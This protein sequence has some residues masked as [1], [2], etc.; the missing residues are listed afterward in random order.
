[1]ATLIE[2]PSFDFTS[3][4]YPELL[5]ELI[6]F[7]R[8]N[9]P[10]I[11]DEN[12]NEPYVQILRAFALVGH[13]NNVNLDIAANETLFQTTRLLKSLQSHLKLIDVQLNQNIPASADV[14]LEFSKIFLV[15]TN[16]VPLNS[17]FATEETEEL[18]QINFSSII[19]YTIDPTNVPTAVFQ[20]DATVFGANK[21]VEASTDSVFFDMFDTTPAALDDKLYI[22]HKDILWDT[23]EFIF[24]TFG[25]DFTGV[26]EFYNGSTD[27]ENPDIVTDMGGFLTVNLTTL[28]GTDDRTNT[29]V[30]IT[31][32]PSGV[33]ET[34]NSYYSGGINYIDTVGILGQTSVSTDETDYSVGTVWNPLTNVVDGIIDFTQDGSITFQLPQTET[35]NWIKTI[36]NN[37]EAYWIRFR[38][39]SHTGTMPSI[40]RIKIDSGKQYL[41]VQTSQGVEVEDNPL[42]SSSGLA[43]QSFIL[44]Q[45][46]LIEI[47]LVI[48]VDEGDGFTEWNIVDNFLNST[49]T[50]K[51][52]TTDIAAN[53]TITIT[54]G[55]GTQGKIPTIGID[56]IQAQYKIGADIDGN[57]GANTININK[58][59]IS[60]VNRVLN[61]RG[62]KG[63]IQKEGATPEDIER[64]K[65]AGPA[66][67][68][69]R[70]RAVTTDDVEYLATQFESSS[71]N[72]LV[73]RALAIEETFGVKT[74]ELVTVGLGGI[75]LTVNEQIELEQYFNGDSAAGIEGVLIANHELT[76]VNYTP[77]VIDIVA[78]VTGGTTTEIENALTALL[79]PNA[80]FSDTGLFRWNF[81][82][83]VPRSLISA[84]IF[85]V[86][87]T[88]IKKVVLTT[89]AIDTV[90]DARELPAIGSISITID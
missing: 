80:I 45:T 34:V 51:H 15:S 38:V 70:N 89:P 47:S 16:I 18:E 10:E 43:N 74:I 55:D 5:R 22:G 1:M 35:E 12:Q 60:F 64:L 71:G 20:E 21:T 11:T 33:S 76:T 62:A 84:E 19:D 79:N 61:P 2:V 24:N 63:W 25:S 39:I 53:N 67:L 65:I 37:V 42:G 3:F 27:D 68:R 36:I 30:T 66:S 7:N 9:S 78:T 6:L 86:D 14:V 90:L 4:Y 57:V 49:A 29:L 40:D 23:I 85:N 75:A 54:F 87:L 46:P 83:E 41:L 82:D 72:K 52:Y 32:T 69:T 28:L 56:N 73:S 88:S 17:K 58:A 77:K 31:Y 8:I 13:L 44:S 50:S 26:W 59:G 81:G 48:N